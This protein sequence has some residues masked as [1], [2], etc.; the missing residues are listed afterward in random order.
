MVESTREAG[1]VTT[2]RRRF[3]LSL[4]AAFGAG[5]AAGVAGFRIWTSKGD[6]SSKAARSVIPADGYE[7]SIS[8]GDSIQRLVAAG[9]VDSDKFRRLYESRGGLAPWVERLF[10]APSAEPITISLETA[11]YLLNLLWPIGLSTKAA[12]NEESPLNGD[13][14]PFFASTGGWTLGREENGAAYFNRVEAVRLSEA[15]EKVV[16]DVAGNCYRPCCDNSAFFQDCNH[17]SALLG[18]LELAASQGI[19]SQELYRVALAANSYWYPRQY[20]ETAVYFK[21]I[22]GRSWHEVPP[23]TV[24]GPRFSTAS[25]WRRN[26]HAALQEANLLPGARQRRQA[27]CAV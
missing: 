19:A 5:T 23:E 16:F 24:L 8:F 21:K 10:A 27:G 2:T 26:V 4:A 11:P 6:G 22:E 25:G 12:F 1:T 13:K 18:L 20:V 17:G 7:T 9:A 3:V 15:Q 14:L